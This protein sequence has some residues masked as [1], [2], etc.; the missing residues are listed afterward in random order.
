MYMQIYIY[1]EFTL[2]LFQVWLKTW[3]YDRI[4]NLR[5]DPNFLY[6]V[7]SPSLLLPNILLNLFHYFFVFHCLTQMLNVKRK[8]RQDWKKAVDVKLRKRCMERWVVFFPSDLKRQRD[9]SA[10]TK[11][12]KALSWWIRS[13][14]RSKLHAYHMCPN[15]IKKHLFRKCCDVSWY[16]TVKFDFLWRLFY[17]FVKAW[18]CF[19][20]FN[21]NVKHHS[22]HCETIFLKF[23]LTV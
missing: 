3:H 8:C 10:I 23:F 2:N 4:R 12:Q 19:F 11:C 5:R 7:F 18:T 21:L 13:T 1:K 9:T 17:I 16:W 15:V 14:H 6:T 20:F 22:T